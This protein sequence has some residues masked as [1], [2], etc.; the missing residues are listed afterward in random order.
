MCEVDSVFGD[1]QCFC[2]SWESV[3]RYMK[4]V[5]IRNRRTQGWFYLDNDFLNLYAK[6]LKPF[7]TLV[8]VA[9]C[10]Y[11]DNVTQECFPS[12][13]TISLECGISPKTVERSIRELEN[14]NIISIERIRKDNGARMNVYTLL[15]KTVWKNIPKDSQSVGST[16]ETN[17]PDPTDLQSGDQPTRVP[18]KDTQKKETNITKL[19]SALWE[20]F[21]S[22]YPKRR[23]DKEKCKNKFLKFSV[24]IQEQIVDDVKKRKDE[25]EKWIKGFVPMTSTYLN[26]KKW[27]DDYEEKTNVTKYE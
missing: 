14:W 6:F 19:K 17:G 25:D 4:E 22:E 9:L 27:Q 20:K 3:F 26:N 15:D 21:W 23:V 13:Q 10:R 2:G 18:C 11:A 12:M 1:Y 16:H 7:S 5:I 8:Y 24:Q